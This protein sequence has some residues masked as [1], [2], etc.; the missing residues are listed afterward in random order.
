MQ[1]TKKTVDKKVNQSRQ[2]Y[3]GGEQ[4]KSFAIEKGEDSD[5]DENSKL[6]YDVRIYRVEDQINDVNEGQAIFFFSNVS[7][8]K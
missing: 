6:Y 3:E 8:G 2:K 4:Q 1:Q 5:E 7:A